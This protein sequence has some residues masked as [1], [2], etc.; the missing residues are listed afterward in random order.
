MRQVV[1]IYQYRDSLIYEVGSWFSLVFPNH[2]NF[3]SFLKHYQGES[4]ILVKAL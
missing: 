2:Y 3:V 1:Y 4:D